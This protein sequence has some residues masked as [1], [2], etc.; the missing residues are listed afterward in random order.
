MA[1]EPQTPRERRYA[2]VLYADISGST[3]LSEI[4]D[5]EEIHE[6]MTACLALLEK[7]ALEHGASLVKFRGDAVLAL[8]GIPIAQ[9]NATRAAVN[10]AI[11]IRNAITA[12]RNERKWP[13]TIDV[14]TGV[15]AGLMVSSAGVASRSSTPLAATS[16]ADIAIGSPIPLSA[17]MS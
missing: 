1:A 10:T 7:T 5:P 13:A 17:R 6:I 2:A 4:L 16:C 9:E 11:E 8:F 15:N 14:H 3:A 12:L